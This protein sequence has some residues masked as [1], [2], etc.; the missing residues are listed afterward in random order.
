MKYFFYIGI[1]LGLIL[2]Q[3]TVPPYVPLFDGFYDVII[4]FVIYLGLFC[5]LSESLPPV[6]LLGFVMDTLSGG[7]FGLYLTTYFW[8]IVGVRWLSKYLHAGN[9]LIFPFIVALG[10]LMENSIFWL[11]VVMLRPAQ[12]QIALPVNEVSVQLV[13]ALFTGPFYLIALRFMHR[14]WKNWR[15]QLAGERNRQ[16]R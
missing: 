10:V 12:Q 13:W 14:N 5:S 2:F 6:F 1:C 15:H 9:S 4:P 3:T 11:T 16:P 8:L 7:P